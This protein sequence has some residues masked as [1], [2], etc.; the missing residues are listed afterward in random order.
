MR[1]EGESHHSGVKGWGLHVH[2]LYTN[3]FEKWRLDSHSPG[4]GMLQLVLVESFT[5]GEAMVALVGLGPQH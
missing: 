1:W 3:S 4:L 5:C 2:A